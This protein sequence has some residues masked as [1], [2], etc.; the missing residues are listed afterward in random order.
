MRRLD[1]LD[2]VGVYWQRREI[3][4]QEETVV[5]VAVESKTVLLEKSFFC[6]QK[7]STDRAKL[8]ILVVTICDYHWHLASGV[9]QRES[10]FLN[11]VIRIVLIQHL[12]RTLVA[13]LVFSQWAWNQLWDLCWLWIS[14]LVLKNKIG[15]KNWCRVLALFFIFLGRVRVDDHLLLVTYPRTTLMKVSKT[16]LKLVV[17]QWHIDGLGT[18][19]ALFFFLYIVMILRLLGGSGLS[20]NGSYEFCKAVVILDVWGAADS[21]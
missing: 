12:L 11:H 6:S 10:S 13:H 2:E 15:R 20:S 16:L 14:R 1:K 5:M 3:C 17:I 7:E 8:K 4:I 9:Y 19:Y 21:A 18:T